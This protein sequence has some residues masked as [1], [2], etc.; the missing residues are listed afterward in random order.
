MI[1]PPHAFALPGDEGFENDRAGEV[2]T[3]GN[4]S[5]IKNRAGEVHVLRYVRSNSPSDT[6][7]GK[8]RKGKGSCKSLDGEKSDV[9]TNDGKD[10]DSEVDHA[11][12]VAHH[13]KKSNKRKKKS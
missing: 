2:D 4:V 11:V 7:G 5:G 6:V 12:G 8:K 1:V 10:S 13:Q 3:G 9:G